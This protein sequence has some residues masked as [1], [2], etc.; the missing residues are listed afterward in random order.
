MSTVAAW[1]LVATTTAVSMSGCITLNLCDE[2]SSLCDEA[3][4][5]GLSCTTI[6]GARVGDDCGV[7]VELGADEG[8]GTKSAPFGS[9]T[10]A[11][12]S[13]AD[14]IYVCGAATSESVTLPAKRSLY[15]GFDCG[16]W[17]FDLA[18]RTE[19]APA[20]DEIPLTLLGGGGTVVEGFVLKAASSA[21]ASGSSIALVADEATASLRRIDLIA[22]NGS[23]GLDGEAGDMGSKGNKG[24]SATG[25][26]GALGGTSGCGA[27]G[28]RGGDG[29]ATPTGGLQ[30]QPAQGNGGAAGCTTGGEGEAGEPGSPG[31]DSSGIGTWSAEGFTA[32]ATGEMG[33]VGTN[34]G[35]AGGG[36]GSTGNGGGG[37]GAGGCIGTPGT[38]G[39]SGGSS[40]AVLWHNASLDFADSTAVVGRGGGG[41][42]GGVG[43]AGGAGGDAGT[44]SGCAGGKGGAAGRAGRGGHGAGG[45][46]LIAAFAGPPPDLMGLDFTAPGEDSG[47]A[48]EG[49]SGVAA[50]SLELSQ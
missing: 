21:T 48:S 18:A 12:E 17:V 14:S 24:A 45:N 46:A 11:I 25:S 28:G 26:T 34:G 8:D 49:E 27:A 44:S 13:G 19:I 29:N 31:T 10:A 50:V 37:G 32:A 9:I 35:G 3:P 5:D 15:G 39:T 7:F 2:Y 20:A 16:E 43:G 6:D 38:P 1:L 42:S 41:G 40:I 23:P 22:G 30:G 33:D 36:G 47:G 4:D